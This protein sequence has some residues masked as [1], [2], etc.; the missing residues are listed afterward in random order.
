MKSSRP[1]SAQWRSSNTRT[2]GAVGG[3][4]LE[5]RPPGREQLVAAAGRRVAD[6]EQGQQRRLDPAP[7]GLVGHVARDASRATFARVVASSSRL[8]QAG[9]AADHLAERPERDA[10]AVG[11]RAALVPLDAARRAPSRYFWNS[12]ASRLLP[13]PAWPGDRDEARP[14]L[15]RRG[16]EQV[17]E[18]A[19]LL[20]AADERRL[21]ALARGRGRR[22]RR[23]PAARARPGPARPCP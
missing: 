18:Q 20:V 14:A 4:P 5:E 23:R 3:D 6:A 2:T 12:Q 9:P 19:Q 8:E 22:A 16:V 21:E 13:M 15:A 1:G 7:L 11:G 10:L 17:L